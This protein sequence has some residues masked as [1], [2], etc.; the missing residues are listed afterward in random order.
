MSDS[1]IE[2]VR[3]G[4]APIENLDSFILEAYVDDKE[5]AEVFSADMTWRVRMSSTEGVVDMHWEDFL[6]IA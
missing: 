4:N 2:F 1:K 5:V 3:A 6:K